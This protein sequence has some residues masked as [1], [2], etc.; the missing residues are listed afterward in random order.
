[1]DMFGSCIRPMIFMGFK[2]NISIMVKVGL[3][4]RA[5]PLFLY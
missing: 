1:M 2:A 3:W 5:L 4:L